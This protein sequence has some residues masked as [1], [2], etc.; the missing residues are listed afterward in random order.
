MLFTQGSGKQF[1]GEGVRDYKRG[2]VALIGSNVPHLHL[3]N[4]KLK[5]SMCGSDVFTEPSAGEAVQ[6]SPELFPA[7]MQYIPD[8]RQVYDLLKK[9]Q[10]GVRFCDEGLYEELL[11]MIKLLDRA[12]YTERLICLLRILERLSQ[13][14]QVELLSEAAYNSSNLLPEADEP[15]NR[16]YAYLYNLFKEDIVLQNIAEQVKLHPSAYRAQVNS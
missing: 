6:F 4:M 7:S 9:S 10:Y 15:V 3:C 5:P 14:Q 13:C 12:E 11:E 1:V 8:Y 16:V 2:D